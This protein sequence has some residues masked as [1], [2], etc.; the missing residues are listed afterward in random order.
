MFF[1]DLSYV[2]VITLVLTA[3]FAVGFRRQRTWPVVLVFFVILFLATW[4]V[5]AWIR[6]PAGMS[7]LPYLVVGLLF[8]LLLTALIPLSRAVRN[9]RSKEAEEKTV[10]IVV[11]D[12]FFWI[13]VIGLI[14][15]IIVRYVRFHY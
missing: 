9:D 5:G 13:L 8:A 3:V 4:A 1:L 2:L 10:A 14:A 15:A 12:L 7:W 11:F 6:P